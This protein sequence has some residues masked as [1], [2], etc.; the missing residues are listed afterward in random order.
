MKILERGIV[1][2]DTDGFFSYHAWPS[3]CI[4]ET[5]VI[6]VV[7]SGA[8]MGHMDPFGKI[9]LFKSRDGGCSFSLPVIVN[10]HYLDDRDPGVLYL[11]GGRLMV[12]RCAHSAGIY[13]NDFADW[14]EQDSGAAG[15]GLLALFPS[16]PEAAS[17]GGS[18]YRILT[19][20]GEQAEAEKRIPVHCPHGPIRLR[21][22]SILY[23]GK[24]LFPDDPAIEDRFFAY[25][26]SDGGASFERIGECVLPPG[27]GRAQYHE[28]HCLELPDGQLTALFR[29]HLI[30]DDNY[31]TLTQCFSADGGR[32]WTTPK[33][34]GICGA[35]PHLCP[36]A[37]GAILTYGRRIPPY[38]IL[39]RRVGADGRIGAEEW[40]L[41]D[42]GDD[43]I[44]YPSTV[45]LPD[46]TFFTVYYARLGGDPT[47]SLLS[48]IWTTE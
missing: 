26:S 16:I 22:G 4:D 2:R 14:I 10:D 15:K 27:S 6:Y 20:Y 40:R 8:R 41:A 3:A 38:G 23:L 45:Q 29:T 12:T 46:G 21:D 35:P 30:A 5:G 25:R 44:G 36:T 34:T 24:A 17:R 9:L 31:F 13:E 43:D 48:V 32:T 11:G 47:A 28:V 42:C 18:Y 33:E 19:A 37:E 1:A 39:G 7:C